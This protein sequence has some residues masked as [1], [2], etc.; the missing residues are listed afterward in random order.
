MWKTENLKISKSGKNSVL[1]DFLSS[2]E[3]FNSVSE[4]IG[5]IYGVENVRNIR[6]NYE[7]M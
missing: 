4:R 1:E 5:G 6:K 7:K 2:T 3:V